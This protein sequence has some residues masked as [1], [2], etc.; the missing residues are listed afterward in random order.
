MSWKCRR[1]QTE[2]EAGCRRG[3]ETEALVSVRGDDRET[4]ENKGNRCQPSSG[5]QGH[6]VESRFLLFPLSNKTMAL[7]RLI[8]WVIEGV[9]VLPS[10][11]NISLAPSS[12]VSLSN[13]PMPGHCLPPLAVFSPRFQSGLPQSVL[14]KRLP[15]QRGQ[16]TW[17]KT[18]S[19]QGG[20]ETS[21][22]SLTIIPSQLSPHL[23]VSMDRCRG[24]VPLTHFHFSDRGSDGGW[25]AEQEEAD[26]QPACRFIRPHY[27]N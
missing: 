10:A 25:Y 1:G 2:G 15:G 3:E 20:T 14:N 22:I 24:M 17:A 11:Q 26:A 12:C 18:S 19:Y 7:H 21:I 27:R 23:R 16:E 8:K 5:K 13:P 4:A 6:T 9:R